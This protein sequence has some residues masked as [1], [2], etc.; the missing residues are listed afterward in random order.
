[1]RNVLSWNQALEENYEPRDYS[2]HKEDIQEG[3]YLASLD[4]KIWSKKIL[5]ITCYL[6]NQETDQK[7]QLTVYRDKKDREYK[8]K[9]CEIDFTQCPIE[10]LYKIKVDENNRGNIKFIAAELIE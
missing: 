1:M 10:A 9:D 6:T 5:G 3:E 7:F 4:F 2:Y 8:L